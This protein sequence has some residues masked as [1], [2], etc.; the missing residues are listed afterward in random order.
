MQAAAPAHSIRR[1]RS[2]FSYQTLGLLLFGLLTPSSP[3]RAAL[4]DVNLDGSVDTADVLLL[5]RHLRGEITL[6]YAALEAADVAPVVDG[7]ASPDD[8]VNL[9]DLAVLSR[10]VHEMMASPAV[11]A[12]MAMPPVPPAPTLDVPANPQVCLN[13]NPCTLVTGTALP[14][15]TVRLIVNGVAID[16]EY[17]DLTGTTFNISALL[18]DGF[19]QVSAQQRDASG[20]WGDVSNEITLEYQNNIDKSNLPSTIT[21]FVVWTEGDGAPYDYATD[22]NIQSGGRLVLMA[23]A[24]V[25]FASGTGINVTS[26]STFQTNGVPGDPVLLTTTGTPSAGA[27]EG[28]EPDY[29]S[30][31]ALLGATIE[32]ARRA[33]WMDGGF[34]LDTTGTFW[35]RDSLV[36]ESSIYGV[37]LEGVV[38]AVIEN[39]TFD[40]ARNFAIYLEYAA[41]AMISQNL[42]TLGSRGLFI[43]DCAVGFDTI[44]IVVGNDFLDNSVGIEVKDHDDCNITITDNVLDSTSWNLEVDP[45]FDGVVI[46]A[47]G[48][49]WGTDSLID[50]EDSILDRA[51][52][53][54]FT[55][56]SAFVDFIPARAADDSVLTFPGMISGPI[57]SGN[58]LAPDTIYTVVGT[59]GVP[60]GETYVF[61]DNVELVFPAGSWLR[62][63]SSVFGPNGSRTLLTGDTQQR[64]HWLGVLLDGATDVS[65]LGGLEIEYAERGIWVRAPITTDVVDVLIREFSEAGIWISTFNTSSADLGI[66]DST[67]TN[68]AGP[69][70]AD[71]VYSITSTYHIVGSTLT[72]CAR[73]VYMDGSFGTLDI[74]GSTISGND[75]GIVTERP[76]FSVTQSDLSNNSLGA[77][78]F[79]GWYATPGGSTVQID[80]TQNWWGAPDPAVVPGQII[81]PEI[82]GDPR[83][84]VDYSD[85]LDGPA[86]TPQGGVYTLPFFRNVSF[87]GPAA[88]QII[89]PL[90]GDIGTVTFDVPLDVDVTMKVCEELAD[91]ACAQ[92]VF[93]DVLSCTGGVPCSMNWDGTGPGQ[94]FVAEEAYAVRLEAAFPGGSFAGVFDRAR[95]SAGQHQGA[96]VVTQINVHR[97]EFYKMDLEVRS[98]G[99]TFTSNAYRTKIKVLNS[100]VATCDPQNQLEDDGFFV[101]NNRPLGT[102][103]GPLPFF[104]DGRDPLG[105]VVNDPRVICWV[106]PP[107]VKPNHFLVRGTSPSV[108]GAGGATVEVKANPFLIRHSYDQVAG[109]TFRVDQDSTVDVMLLPPGSIDPATKLGFLKHPDGTDWTGRTVNGGVDYSAEWFGYT[110]ADTNSILAA[111]EGS[112]TFL[113]QATSETT[114]VETTYYGL[115]QVRH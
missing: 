2:F 105:A 110:A 83:V 17:V 60:A 101:R 39:S 89:R 66:I 104:W 11:A 24:T 72:G 73:G 97:N 40:N 36:R 81:V 100:G 55:A 57:W 99:S 1:P 20:M 71:C 48:N 49:Y 41:D 102:S 5:E 15:N 22:L 35:M 91:E 21:S 65:A 12:S 87:L 92:P 23:G 10:F 113:I 8:Q 16:L 75:R 51:D 52:Y 30:D 63:D 54:G 61:P 103:E 58:P 88:D 3:A 82:N 94:T 27:W 42:I 19:N 109:V 9:G 62:G 70:E 107:A 76:A 29:R 112:H 69:R 111:G 47:E 90:S 26:T 115:L 74:S 106:D 98:V 38:Q 4:G 108:G 85:L 84:Q 18:F 59:V 13:A 56:D 78:V 64:G 6:G 14:G 68:S 45:N 86:G 32:Y 53:L 37:R 46:N 34:G 93:T 43:E 114:G 67:I 96:N 33:V 79:Q 95:P 50:I 25:R 28:V 77:L 7:M 80:A 44:G 31:V